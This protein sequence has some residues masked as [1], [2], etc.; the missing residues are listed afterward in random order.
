VFG[1]LLWQHLT[2]LPYL[3]GTSDLDLL[4]PVAGAV[5]ARLLPALAALDADAPMRL[6]GE[7]V[8][9]DGRGVNWRELHAAAPD[10]AV[11][12]KQRDG[13]A[14]CA[15]RSLLAGTSAGEAV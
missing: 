14:L 12:A 11:L 1:S 15:A 6:D 8:L 13:L 10:E 2:G 4:W 3:S 9:P 7:I 5:D